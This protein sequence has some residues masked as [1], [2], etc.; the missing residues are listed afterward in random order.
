MDFSR[1]YAAVLRA[2]NRAEWTV[3]AETLALE[4]IKKDSP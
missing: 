3:N 1:A 2:E 4:P